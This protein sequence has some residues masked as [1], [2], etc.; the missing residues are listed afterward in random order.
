MFDI[1]GSE[2]ILIGVVALIVIGPKDLPEMFRQLGRVTAKMRSMARDFQRAMDQAAK[3]SGVSDV[4]NDL[5][6]ATS[7]KSLGID[8]VR[9]AANK[10]E[11]WDPI[12]N[13]LRPTTPAPP[14]TPAA[15]PTAAT[16]ASVIGPATA[17]LAEKQAQKKAI[18][19]ETAAKLK[20]VDVGPVAAEKPAAK[21]R[22]KA[23]KPPAT[24]IATAPKPRAPRKSVKKADTV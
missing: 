18:L 14:A 3:E 21:P 23:A 5:K 10:F 4:A 12:G 19:Q 20:A 15:P 13:T 9:Q 8:A 6:S 17:A 24:E 1:G 11:K 7:S 2:L 16:P 22:A